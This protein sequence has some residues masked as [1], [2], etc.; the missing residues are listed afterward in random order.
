MRQNKDA[1]ECILRQFGAVL[2]VGF[3]YIFRKFHKC[4]CDPLKGPLKNYVILFWIF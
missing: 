2:M 4:P 3:L 1:H